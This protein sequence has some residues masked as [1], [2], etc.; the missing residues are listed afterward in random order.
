ML[1]VARVSSKGQVTIPKPVRERL[2]LKTG[3]PLV[4]VER[5]DRM[6][7]E[8]MKGSILEWYGA[9]SVEGPLDFKAV[10]EQTMAIA[11]EEVAHE[12]KGD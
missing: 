7:L 5:D 3:S 2:E 12:G 8:S 10:R 1:W 9:I 4:F 6:E 11:A